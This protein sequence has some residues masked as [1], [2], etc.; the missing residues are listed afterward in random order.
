[1]KHLLV[2]AN[3][4]GYFYVL[5]RTNGKFLYATPF[6]QKLNWAKGVDAS[7]RPILTGKIPTPE[8]TYIC[9][10]IDGATNW[11]SPSYNPDTGLFYVL[12]LENCNIVFAKPRKFVAGET[13]YNTGTIHSSTEKSEKILLALS[14]ADGKAVWS[15][16]QIGSGRSWGGT[17]TTAGGLLF[18]G[19]DSESLEAV[20]A[21]HG[22]CSLALQ[23]RPDDTC[24]TDDLCRRWCAVCCRGGRERHLQ[25]L[26]AAMNRSRCRQGSASLLLDRTLRLAALPKADARRTQPAD[27]RHVLTR[28]QRF[29]L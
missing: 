24:L 20:D 2:Q 17:L 15:Y 23:Y 13:F 27:A 10:G 11:F 16:P 3:R 8:G 29:F 28:S 12:A 6:V 26:V 22:T 5:D 9:P 21:S 19:D 7:G 4:N 14:L 1:M 18:F 25:F